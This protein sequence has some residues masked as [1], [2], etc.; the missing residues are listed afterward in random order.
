[1]V[2]H[3][4]SRGENARLLCKYGGRLVMVVVMVVVVES[5]IGWDG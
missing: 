2:P 1:M 5:V 4:K 3:T